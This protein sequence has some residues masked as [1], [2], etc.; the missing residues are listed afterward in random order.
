M[1][2]LEFGS[3]RIGLERLATEAAKVA[4]AAAERVMAEYR[5]KFD[6]GE[7]EEEPAITGRLAQAIGDAFP[8]LN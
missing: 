3:E 2:L 6:A 8:N 7:R 4:D 5:K 1:S